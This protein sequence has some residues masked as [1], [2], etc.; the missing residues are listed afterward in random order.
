MEERQGDGMRLQKHLE[1]F[2]VHAFV[3][4]EM[5]LSSFLGETHKD[6]QISRAFQNNQM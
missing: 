5:G 3:P 2:T 1:Q 6:V 4:G